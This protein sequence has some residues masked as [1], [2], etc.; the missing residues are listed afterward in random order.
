MGLIVFRKFVNRTEEK[1]GLEDSM[2]CEL[3]NVYWGL[4]TGL[5]GIMPIVTVAL[6]LSKQLFFWGRV[7]GDAI[8]S[9]L[10]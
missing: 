10:K 7:A 3:D 1:R 4:R 2:G 9:L 5:L 8:R 6:E